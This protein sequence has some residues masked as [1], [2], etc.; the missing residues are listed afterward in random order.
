MKNLNDTIENIPKSEMQK[1]KECISKDKLSLL[2]NMLFNIDNISGKNQNIDQKCLEH[3]CSYSACDSHSISRNHLKNFLASSSDP[4]D[5][6]K[7]NLLNIFNIVQSVL[8]EKDVPITE[9][10]NVKSASTFKGYCGSNGNNHDGDYFKKLDKIKHSTEQEI[11]LLFH[12]R[13]L[14]W[15]LRNIQN[16]LHFEKDLLKNFN[17]IGNE[18]NELLYIVTKDKENNPWSTEQKLK[19]RIAEYGKIEIN[20]K[21]WIKNMLDY[22]IPK[23]KSILIKEISSQDFIGANFFECNF[24]V[25][26][27]LERLNLNIFCDNKN[28]TKKRNRNK[29]EKLE[30]GYSFSC[31]IINDDNRIMFLFVTDKPYVDKIL[32]RKFKK[33]KFVHNFLQSFLMFHDDS[34]TFF[35]K[36]GLKQRNV[37]FGNKFKIK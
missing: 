29:K 31:G 5:V 12:F 30:Y 33:E 36:E 1:F 2:K 28:K 19:I 10:I 20:I 11:A 22:G 37:I 27:K 8:S 7:S 17:N 6:Y 35:S 9:K 13:M 26:Q 25:E 14:S 15:K 16:M 32:K 23:N 34:N 18:L 24:G 4:F 21:T 3:L